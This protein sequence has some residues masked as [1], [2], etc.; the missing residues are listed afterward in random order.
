MEFTATPFFILLFSRPASLYFEEYVHTR[1][2][3]YLNVATV[4]ELLLLPYK[5]ASET[6]L[7]KSREV[8]S[9]DGIF[10]IVAPTWR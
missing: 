10:I 8:R 3:T 2:H 1:I 5:P 6:F 7:H 4:Y 9:V